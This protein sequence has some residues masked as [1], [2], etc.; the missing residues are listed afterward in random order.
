MKC[1][2]SGVG[3][4]AVLMQNDKPLSFWSMGLKGKKLMFSTY[5][6]ELFS[7]VIRVKKWW[8]CLLGQPFK[9]KTD[10]KN[11]KSLLD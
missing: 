9:I 8:P 5:E 11:L 6:N 1:D 7:I 10:S 4:W 3:I 2:I